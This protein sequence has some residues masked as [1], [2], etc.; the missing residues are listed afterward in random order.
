MQNNNGISLVD[1]PRDAIQSISPFI[2]T[3]K[4]IT[5]IQR[6][7]DSG[8]FDAVD[9]GSFVSHRLVPQMRD[10]HQ[11]LSGLTANQRVKLLAVVAN[12]R[13]AEEA[14]GTG[15]IDYIG[16]PFSISETFQQ[17]N[18]NSSIPQALNTIQEIQLRIGEQDRTE[19]VVYL[20]MAFGNPYGDPWNDQ[21]VTHRMEQLLKLGIKR[22]SLADTTAEAHPDRVFSVIQA[23]TDAFPQVSFSVHLH[24]LVEDALLKIDA[25][26]QAGC[27]RFEGALLGYGGCPFAQD[28]LVGN[29]PSEL[30]IDRFSKGSYAEVA[31]LMDAFQKLIRHDV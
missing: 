20:S 9:F 13:G 17:R 31:P 22:F 2:A 26:F 28:D 27:R 8:L 25:A 24:S 6:L 14:I 29:I 21:Q 1:C 30:L 18:T 12:L 23:V 11:V 10:T 4:K 5:Y 3:E 7:I 15:K 19:L 16:Y